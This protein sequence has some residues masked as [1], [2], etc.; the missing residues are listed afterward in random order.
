MSRVARFPTVAAVLFA[1]AALLAILAILAILAAWAAG[2]PGPAVRAPG[3]GTEFWP[4]ATAS[5]SPG[6][7]AAQPCATATA[8]GGAP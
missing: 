4:V 2:Q 3:C 6:V 8:E 5:A 1:A 7:P